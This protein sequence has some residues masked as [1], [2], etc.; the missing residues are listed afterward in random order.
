MADLKQ[1]YGDSTTI[2]LT[3]ASLADASWRQALA[4]D[5]GSNLFLDALL[6]GK[7]KTGTGSAAGDYVDLYVAASADGGTTFGGDCSGSDAAYSGESDNLVHLGRVSTPGAQT[8]FEFGPLSIA[9]A[10]GGVL[11]QRWTLVVENRSGSTLD[12]TPAN[13]DLHYM[14]VYQ[15]S[16]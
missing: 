13:H 12:A 10:F 14:G 15:Q 2:T 1:K 16:N 8:T 6:G 11:P 9:A 7:I 5:N 4:V 3:L